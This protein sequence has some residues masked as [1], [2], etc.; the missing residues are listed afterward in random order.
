M[1]QR[2]VERNLLAL[3]QVSKVGPYGWFLGWK[4]EWIKD[5]VFLRCAV[6]VDLCFGR[7]ALNSV[8]GKQ[9]IERANAL[10]ASVHEELARMRR[11]TMTLRQ[12]SCL[13]DT[14]DAVASM[15]IAWS[16]K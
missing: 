6:D 9:Y 13:V 2:A 1:L 4:A 11:M 7:S 16:L 5:G 8:G 10:S 3:V 12:S 15:L 14:M